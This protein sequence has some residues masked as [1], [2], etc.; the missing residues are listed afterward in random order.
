MLS[1]KHLCFLL[2]VYVVLVEA[3]QQT[4]SEFLETESNTEHEY[5]A[6]STA[7]TAVLVGDRLLVA[8][9]GDSGFIVVRNGDVIAKSM[10]MQRGFNFPYQ[11][12]SDGDDPSIAEVR[13]SNLNEKTI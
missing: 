7:S 10:P 8:N 11:I 1:L 12:G 5:D 13:N 4:D 2:N 6:G 3:F 9:V